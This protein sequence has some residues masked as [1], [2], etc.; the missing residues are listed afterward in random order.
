MRKSN[1]STSLIVPFM[2][3]LLLFVFSCSD[4]QNHSKE[5]KTIDSLDNVVQL[6]SAVGVGA[7]N[8]ATYLPMIKKKKT[9]L[10]VNHSSR[11]GENHLID[12]LLALDVNIVKIF[13]PEHGFTGKAANGEKISDSKFESKGSIPL[14]SLY[15]K[16]RKPLPE[17]LEGVEIMIFDIQDVGVRF[18]TYISTMHYIMEAGAENGIPVIVLD[19]PNPNGH[20]VDGPVLDT[21]W[22]SFIGMHPI[23]IVH[24]L[25][26]GELAKMIN[27]EGWLKNGIQCQ[28]EVIKNT[29]YTH[30]TPYTL[31]L[32]PSPNLPDQLSVLLYPSLCLFEGTPISIGRGTNRPFTVIGHP[33]F[34][35]MPFTFTP[36]ANEGSKYPK[37]E[38]QICYGHDLSDISEEN[39]RA[40]GELDLKWITLWAAMW[41]GPQAFFNENKGIDRLT[42]SD[43][44]RKQVEGGTSEMAI[45][46]SWEPELKEYREMRKK[47]LLYPDFE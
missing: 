46:E 10:V 32:P 40:R 37:F 47:Y 8:L 4:S 25:T 17:D 1:F 14:I 3:F 33:N 30:N 45:R 24:G 34:T 44:F 26:V 22:R 11:V 9:A 27:G 19:R 31:P 6:S 29:N 38:D 12:T 35:S 18:Y 5:G 43:Q 16:K 7:E 28:L 21:A 2:T 23:P 13:S 36:K 41:T 39:F 15:G 42:G 20:Y